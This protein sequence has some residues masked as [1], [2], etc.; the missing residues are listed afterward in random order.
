MMSKMSPDDLQ[1]M[2]GSTSLPPGMDASTVKNQIEHLQQNPEML[3]TAMDSLQAMPEEERKKVIAQRYGAAASGDPRGADPETF[4]KM[5]E[6]PEVLQQAISMT[7]NISDEDMKRF[8]LGSPDQADMMRR[9]AEQMASNP[10]LTKQMSEMMKNMSP[11]QLESMMAMSSQMRGGGGPAGTSGDDGLG[12][13]GPGLGPGGL[14]PSALMSDP[15]MLKMTEQMIG[16]MSPEAMASMARASG[17]DL[18]EDKARLVARMLPWLMKLMRWF[19]YLRKGW[20]WCWTRNGRIAVAG[21][22]LAAAMYQHY[23]TS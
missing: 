2:M 6:N 18:S 4:G 7:K 9:T 5:F 22:V 23:R 8:N 20:S 11:E 3:K 14:D 12:P 13:G 1:K 10:G 15:D 16:N 19:S 17:L 21:L